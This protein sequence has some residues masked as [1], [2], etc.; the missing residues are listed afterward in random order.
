RERGVEFI[1]AEVFEGHIRVPL[2]AS[3]SATELLLQ[4]EY[5]EFLRRTDLDKLRPDHEILPTSLGRYDEIWDHVLLHQEWMSER[6][7]GSV[8]TP[9]AVTS[10]YDTM[11]LPIFQVVRELKVTRRFPG[12]TEADI[13]LWVM[14]HRDELEH[15]YGYE[16]DPAESAT[17]YANVLA[18]EA[19][20]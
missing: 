1:D 19:R 11:Y 15:R 9:E 17:D 2:Y 13:Y 5:A 18:N 8:A 3:M 16:V 7:G 12:R 14:A 6:V 4:V 10:W 20:L